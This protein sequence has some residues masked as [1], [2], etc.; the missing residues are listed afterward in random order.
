MMLLQK[1]VV[2]DR[3]NH[4]AP[5]HEHGREIDVS[6]DVNDIRI[7]SPSLKRNTKTIQKSFAEPTRFPPF[8]L[9]LGAFKMGQQLPEG[10]FNAKVP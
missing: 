4:L 8:D 9:P 7:Q 3:Q 10:I 1:P 2:M 6:R 5:G